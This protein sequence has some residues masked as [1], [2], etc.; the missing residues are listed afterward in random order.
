LGSTLSL[1]RETIKEMLISNEKKDGWAEKKGIGRGRD[2]HP[3]DLGIIPQ[4]CLCNAL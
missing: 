3:L 2:Y 1:K 4:D